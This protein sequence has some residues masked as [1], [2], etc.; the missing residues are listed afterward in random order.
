VVNKEDTVFCNVFFSFLF[1]FSASKA[2][3]FYCLGLLG[4]IDRKETAPLSLYL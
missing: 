1:F 4:V 2:K 3:L